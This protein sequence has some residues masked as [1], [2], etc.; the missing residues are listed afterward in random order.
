M[1]RLV[2]NPKDLSRMNMAFFTF[3]GAIS[4]I[5]FTATAISLIWKV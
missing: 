1:Q 3:N 2:V 4:I 5:L